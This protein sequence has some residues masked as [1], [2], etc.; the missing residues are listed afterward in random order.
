MRQVAGQGIFHLQAG[1]AFI[2]DVH[3]LDAI[4]PSCNA[5][6]IRQY[7]DIVVTAGGAVALSWQ[8]ES[9]TSGLAAK[10]DHNQRID[11]HRRLCPIYS[12]HG[13][14]ARYLL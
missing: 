4:Q 9:E 8:E 5:I 7:L 1:G 10:T 11:L 3:N 6:W 13:A 2:S 12:D 14:E